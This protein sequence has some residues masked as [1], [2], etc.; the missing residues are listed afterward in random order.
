METKELTPEQVKQ[1]N[2]LALKFFLGSFVNGAYHALMLS[3][4]NL[5]TM[6][7]VLALE[8]PELLMYVAAIGEGIFVFSRMLSVAK[9]SHDKFVSDAKKITEEDK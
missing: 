5:V 3:L 9:E 1:L 2:K 4:M 8:L 6:L 7:A